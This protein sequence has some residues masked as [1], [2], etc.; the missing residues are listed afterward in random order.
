VDGPREVFIFMIKPFAFCGTNSRHL[1]QSVPSRVPLEISAV[2]EKIISAVGLGAPRY[3]HVP[4][5]LPWMT[6]FTSSELP[7]KRAITEFTEAIRSG[8][9]SRK[10]ID[11]GL[12]VVELIADLDALI[13]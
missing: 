4:R 10:S 1:G 5:R 11:L 6:I 9:K 2:I 13:G 7:L 8:V 3:R 12:S